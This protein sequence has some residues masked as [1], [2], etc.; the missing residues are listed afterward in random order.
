MHGVGDIGATE[1]GDTDMRI[2][3]RIALAL[4]AAATAAGAAAFP[5]AAQEWPT[6]PLSIVVPFP[7]GGAAD[8]LGRALADQL[9]RRLGQQVV[10]ENRPGAGAAIGAAHVARS[11]PD[12]HTLLIGTVSTHAMNPIL[13]P[14]GGYDPLA[15]FTPIGPIADVPFVLVVH[16]SVAAD[17]VP[18]LIELAKSRPGAL[19]YASAGN[20][21]SNHLAGELFKLSTGTDMLHVPYRGS[22]PALQDTMA[23][24]TQVMFDLAVTALAQMRA[25]TVRALAVTGERRSPRAPDLPTVAETVPG[26]GVTAWFGLFGPAGMPAAAT[27]RLSEALRASLDDPEMKRL[28]DAQGAE[29]MS[30]SPAEFADFVR[31]EHA[32][33]GRVIREA[34][35]AVQN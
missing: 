16:P 9:T 24:Q 19:A 27:A 7:P 23:G 10:V 31:A 15:D 8:V 30:A 32:K 21:T 6:R 20:G 18:A 33:W 34:G 29:A 13:N 35:I 2:T 5:A 26:Y 11:A 22:A 25:G 3:R 4:V 14:D 17:G 12:G 28:L 1:R